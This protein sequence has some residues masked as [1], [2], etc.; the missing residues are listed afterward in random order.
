MAKAPDPS[1]TKAADFRR[2]AEELRAIVEAL[3]TVDA[4]GRLTQPSDAEDEPDDS[5]ECQGFHRVDPL[6]Q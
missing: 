3:L 4:A 2:R 5:N 1:N 6:D